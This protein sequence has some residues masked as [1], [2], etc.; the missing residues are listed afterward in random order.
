MNPSQCQKNDE[1]IVDNSQISTQE[2][3]SQSYMGNVFE[4]LVRQDIFERTSTW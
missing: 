4:R 3:D 2:N 1:D